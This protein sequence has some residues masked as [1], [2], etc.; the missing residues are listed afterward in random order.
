MTNRYRY[1]C[2]PVVLYL[3]QQKWGSDICNANITCLGVIPV[4]V[5]LSKKKKN[6]G[7]SNLFF[8]SPV[9]GYF[10]LHLRYIKYKLPDS[11]L[12]SNLVR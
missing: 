12:C 3:K 1:V 5:Q 11:V 2:M 8:W 9:Q 7:T 10:T 6:G 4:L